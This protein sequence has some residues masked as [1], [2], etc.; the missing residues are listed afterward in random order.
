MLAYGAFIFVFTFVYLESTGAILPAMNGRIYESLTLCTIT[1]AMMNAAEIINVMIPGFFFKIMRE[2]SGNEKYNSHSYGSDHTTPAFT[3]SVNSDL[4]MFGVLL[5]VNNSQLSTD[6]KNL[7]KGTCSC[8]PAAMSRI[9]TIA[10][11]EK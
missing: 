5:I 1:K 11:T 6:S 3:S 9:I 10:A 8:H 4:L 7:G 2:T